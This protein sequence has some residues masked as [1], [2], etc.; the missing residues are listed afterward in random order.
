[1]SSVSVTQEPKSIVHVMPL[2]VINSYNNI[3]DHTHRLVELRSGCLLVLHMS[4]GKG[5]G[6]RGM[7]RGGGE[8]GMGRG[9]ERREGR[10][11]ERGGEER[12]EEKGGVK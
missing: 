2:M 7:G 10:R 3:C 8:R 11:G 6:E 5:E 12:G 4:V 9:E 1:M